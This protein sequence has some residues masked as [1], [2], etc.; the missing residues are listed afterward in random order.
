MCKKNVNGEYFEFCLSPLHAKIRFFEYYLYL[1]YES[2]IKMWQA[3]GP[4]QKLKVLD[5]KHK[6]QAAFREEMGIIVGKSR[7]EVRGSS[8]DGNVAKHFSQIPNLASEI[9]GL[10][11]NRIHRCAT[12]LQVFALGYKIF[13]SYSP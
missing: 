10:N 5:Q 11:K 3:R 4:K 2:V 1:S 7:D 12:I 8:N 9:T 6:I 13:A